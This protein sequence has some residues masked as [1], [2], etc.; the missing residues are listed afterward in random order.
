MVKITFRFSDGK[1][2]VSNARTGE[3]L[4]EVAKTAGVDIDAPC[5]GSGTCGKC[6]V[7][8]VEGTLE[9]DKSRHISEEDWNNGWRLACQ[10]KIEDNCTIDVPDSASAFKTGMELLCVLPVDETV[11]EYDGEGKPTSGLPKDN[12]MKAALYA[13]LDTLKF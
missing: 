9:A 7:R 11:Y 5:G 2:I 8:L 4:M 3:T 13:A 6:R 1:E 12:P 10:S